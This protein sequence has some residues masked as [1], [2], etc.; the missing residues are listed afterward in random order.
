MTMREHPDDITLDAYVEDLLDAA[1]RARLDVHLA[2]C[3]R[4]RAEVAQLTTLRGALRELPTR[5]DPG[6]DLRPGI[7]AEHARRVR[8]GRHRGAMRSLRMP[9]AAAA[10]LLVAVTAGVTALLLGDS[11]RAGRVADVPR[12]VERR[13]GV[14][15]AAFREA[16]SDYV[17]TA[18]ELSALLE[19][20]RGSLA[21]ET[22]RLV[23]EN[24]RTIDQALSEAE[25][26]LRA[27]PASS[28]LHELILD[29]HERKVEVLRWA[30]S[31][32]RDT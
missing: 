17:R 11:E 18:E 13:D 4:C 22:V 6:A 20:H 25:A 16:R 14:S 9:L 8:A 29:T 2:E 30:E 23:E 24:L 5:I 15:P 19:R 10:V 3:A 21:P 28:V 27:D 12:S 7:R 31:L 26:A 32:A 1:G